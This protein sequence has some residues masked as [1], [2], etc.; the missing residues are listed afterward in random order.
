VKKF[1]AAILAVLIILAALSGILSGCQ[2]EKEAKPLRAN[3]D[4]VFKILHMS[5]FHEYLAMEGKTAITVKPMKT[6]TPKLIEYLDLVTEQEK[7]DFV[8]LG[9]DNIFCNSGFA[10]VVYN[11]SIRTY[12]KIAEYFENK[13]IYWTFVFGNHD[14]ESGRRKSRIISAV[15]PYRYF[16]GG[17]ESGESFDAL[18]IKKKADVFADG[19]KLAKK[20]SI[21]HRFA[22]YFIKVYDASGDNVVYNIA[23]LDTGSF[24]SAPP[25]SVHYKRLLAEQFSWL[26]AEL[27]KNAAPFCIFLHIAYFSDVTE[28]LDDAALARLD[29]I[30]AGHWHGNFNYLYSDPD[31]DILFLKAI[32]GCAQGGGYRGETGERFARAIS[33]DTVSGAVNSYCLDENAEIISYTAYVF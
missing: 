10:E 33:I 6:L 14:A 1:A 17:K 18:T 29:G 20:Y 11:T 24:Y 9:G 15:E 2:K 7:P 30:F 27:E 21:D 28:A 5:D 26:N 13:K 23:T 12:K 22:N 19:K 16:I 31:K 25:A 4:G 8:V 3:A 32:T